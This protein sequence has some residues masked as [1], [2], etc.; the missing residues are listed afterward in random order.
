VDEGVPRLGVLWG[1]DKPTRHDIDSL[2]RRLTDLRLQHE[3]AVSATLLRV[4]TLER[5]T[6]SHNQIIAGAVAVAVIGALAWIF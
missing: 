5:R 6:W 2:E 4:R 3:A 1:G